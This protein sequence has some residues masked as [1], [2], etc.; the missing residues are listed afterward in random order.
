MAVFAPPVGFFRCVGI[1]SRSSNI[2][3]APVLRKRSA[4]RGVL[5]LRVGTGQDQPNLVGQAP[6][7]TCTWEPGSDGVDRLVGEAADGRAAH[8]ATPSWARILAAA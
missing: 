4:Q 3:G 8:A 1:G 2:G 7:V 5:P 6:I